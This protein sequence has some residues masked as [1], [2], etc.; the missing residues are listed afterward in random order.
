[1]SYHVIMPAAGTGQRLGGSSLPKCLHEV[2]G[3]PLLLHTLD[4]LADHAH[5]LTLIV[6]H[7]QQCLRDRLG[8]R[9]RDI[10]IDYVENADYATT[11]H[12]YSLALA[13]P[14]WQESPDDILFMDADNA[15]SPALLTRLLAAPGPDTLLVDAGLDSVRREEELVLG[16]A[17]RVTGLVRGHASDHDDCVGGFVGM[18]RLSAGF[19]AVLFDFLQDFFV[20]NHRRYKYERLFHRLVRSGAVSLDYL[21]TGG[22]PWV[23]VNHPEDVV[24]AER[25]L[26]TGGA[27]V[28]AG[29]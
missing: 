17:G 6:G 15:F 5:R 14:S 27:A 26:S 11:E 9:H 3:R 18:N 1:M 8:V 20:S 2:A 13:G 10:R 24:A 16:R 23:N 29:A 22:L 7:G 12:G 19:V 21:D 25:I 28:R 4:S